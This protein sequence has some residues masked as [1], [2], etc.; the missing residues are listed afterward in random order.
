M[1]D[2]IFCQGVVGGSS[3]RTLILTYN[4]L[5]GDGDPS[6]PVYDLQSID[7][8]LGAVTTVASRIGSVCDFFDDQIGCRVKKESATKATV[9]VEL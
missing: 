5:N 1:P 8:N 9:S 3:A 4:A 2:H 7:N 6:G